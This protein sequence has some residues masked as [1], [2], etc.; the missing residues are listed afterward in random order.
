MV[1]LVIW[2][3]LF[4]LRVTKA[5][6]QWLLLVQNLIMH[7]YDVTGVK[8]WIKRVENQ[9]MHLKAPQIWSVKYTKFD[10]FSKKHVSMVD[11]M[12]RHYFVSRIN[13]LKYFSISL[14]SIIAVKA[15]F[16]NC[17]LF[18]VWSANY[19]YFGYVDRTHF[20]SSIPI[21]EVEVFIDQKNAP[22]LISHNMH[23]TF[24]S[25]SGLFSW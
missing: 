4:R 9:I 3:V 11:L 10:N 8:V 13:F 2:T 20:S 23:S 1:L 25:H 15:Y 5:V 14:H 21:R 22:N 19:G 18:L 16:H 17:D 7:V 12:S 24:P 6:K